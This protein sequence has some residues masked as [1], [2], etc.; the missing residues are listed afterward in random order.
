MFEIF[1]QS[2][3][4][5]FITSKAFL[6]CH[7]TGTIIYHNIIIITI[8]GSYQHLRVMSVNAATS[9]FETCFNYVAYKIFN[10]L[11]MNTWHFYYLGLFLFN[12]EKCFVVKSLQRE[13]LMLFSSILKLFCMRNH[14]SIFHFMDFPHL[15]LVSSFLKFLAW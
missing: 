2:S 11:I 6:G 13:F 12:G 3:T 4:S 14:F 9:K 15:Q 1:F 7:W 10:Y 8:T 5:P